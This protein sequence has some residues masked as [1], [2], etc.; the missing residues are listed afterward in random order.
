[1]RR[2]S[3]SIITLFLGAVVGFVGGILLAPSSGNNVRKVLSYK[4]KNYAEKF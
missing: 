1:M 3:I 4:I 2:N